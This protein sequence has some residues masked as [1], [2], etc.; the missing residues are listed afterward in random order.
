MNINDRYNN[1]IQ[2]IVTN[3]A[4]IQTVA[5]GC[6]FYAWGKATRH[7]WET[8]Q[9]VAPLIRIMGHCVWLAILI[10]VDYFKSGQAQAHWQFVNVAV[11]DGLGF[12]GKSPMGDAL[13]AWM[14]EAAQRAVVAVARTA[15]KIGAA[16]VARYE[17]V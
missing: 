5:V 17:A 6:T 16:V 8:D 7:W 2:S 13:A 3:D 12:Y 4:A 9:D 14:Q 10:T 11:D 15:K 1:T